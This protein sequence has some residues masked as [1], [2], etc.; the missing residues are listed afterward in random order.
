MFESIISMLKANPLI[1]GGISM[2]VVGWLIVQA[3]A[4]PMKLLRLLQDQFSTSMV[5][6]SEDQVFRRLDLWLAR[7]P[8]AKH[9]RRF[10]VAAYHDRTIDDTNFA[11]T[12]GPGF[13]LLR[14]GLKFYLT[15]R[16]MDEQTTAEDFSKVRKQTLTI[17]TLGRKAINLEQLLKDIQEVNEDKTTV[18]VHLWS[19]HGYVPLDRKPKR[20]MDTVYAAED[21]KQ[22][23][24]ADYTEFQS[25][26][27]WYIERG[28]PYRRGY[29]FE[30]PPGTGKTTMILALA[31]L[32][33]KPIYIINPASIDNDNELQ[34]AV[35]AAGSHFVIIEDIDA[36]EAAEERVGKEK[37]AVKTGEASKA[38]ITTSG[39]LNAID[40]IGAREGRVLFITTNRPETIDA[41]LLRAGRIDRRY[42][43]D[44]I[45][46]TEASAMFRRFFPE[47]DLPAFQADI[48]NLLPIPPATLQNKLL[49][50]T[51]A[52]A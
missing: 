50:L 6:Y 10:G 31:S 38:G 27:E 33:D 39:L 20:H 36:V 45:G 19:G 44:N 51:Q 52:A 49:G 4:V 32:F 25:N 9:S 35:N 18:P 8:S 26:K 5:V 13:H 40:G 42:R 43:L 48:E 28:I 14:N 30:G 16:H 29:M 37:P 12:P 7:H 1:A 21:I 41:A 17:T 46:M 34:R 2:A 22:A 47:G 11:L 24:I 3:K 23:L 15:H